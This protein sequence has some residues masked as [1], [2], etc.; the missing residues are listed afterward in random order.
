LRK[1]REKDLLSISRKLQKTGPTKLD[2]LIEWAKKSPIFPNL[3]WGTMLL[4]VIYV[5][6]ALVLSV[7]RLAFRGWMQDVMTWVFT[8]LA[9]ITAGRGIVWMFRRAEA[10]T[11]K[12]RKM[13]MKISAVLLIVITVLAAQFLILYGAFSH[14]PEHI[15]TKYDMEMI[16]S[17]YGD[18]N[19]SVDY[20]AHR[21]FLVRGNDLLGYEVYVDHVGDPY[22]AETQPD[23]TWFAFDFSD[24][25]RVIEENHLPES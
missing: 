23:P 24:G 4:F 6:A 22:A 12:P 8:A 2:R 9:L 11:D 19:T 21:N 5:I 18:E 7:N 1:M 13:S 14:R 25:D 20:Y 10:I 16:A 17:V 3:Y 15:V